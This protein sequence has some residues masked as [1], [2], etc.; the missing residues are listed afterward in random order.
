MVKYR[1]NP[2][3]STNVVMNGPEITAGSSFNLFKIKGNTDETM[4]DQITMN[5]PVIAT[6]CATS[7]PTPKV[8]ARIN[9]ATANVSPS[10]RPTNASFFITRNISLNF[11]SFRATAR[12]NVVT[13][14]VPVF[15]PVPINNGIKKASAT[16]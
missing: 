12:T 6:T 16:T 5:N 15:P 10:K 8:Y 14:C 9:A 7:V 2:V 13:T 3:P 1:I 4:D 11:T